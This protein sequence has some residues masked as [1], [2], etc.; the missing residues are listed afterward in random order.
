MCPAHRTERIKEIKERLKNNEKCV[1]VSTQ[2]IEAGVDIDFPVVYRELAGIDSIAQAAG[3]CNRERKIKEGGRVYVF[4]P[5][6][7]KPPAGF[8]ARTVG[9][10]KEV[11]DINKKMDLL[12]L[13]N[14]KYY[15]EKLYSVDADGLDGKNILRNIKNSSGRLEYPFK[16]IANDFNLIDNNTFS[17]VIRYDE[18]CEEILKDLNFTKYPWS[19]ARKLQRYTVQVYKQ[20]YDKLEKIG[21][22]KKI[23][24]IYFVVDKDA[25]SEE[26]GMNV[27]DSSDK[28]SE[29][30]IV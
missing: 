15:F 6:D 9:V 13:K 5:V 1:V 21:K 3:R 12:S 18:K 11:F 7:R 30:Y 17:L 26:F 2:L 27:Q 10:T 28:V 16:T 8:I 4:K 25:Y 19:Y 29:N 24:D 23:R 22:V 20:D 14:I